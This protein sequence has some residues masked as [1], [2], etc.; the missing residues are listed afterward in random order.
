MKSVKRLIFVITI[1]IKPI[2]H[3][4][5]ASIAYGEKTLFSDLDLE[6]YPGNMYCIVGDSGQGKTSLL[7]SILGFIPLKKG[8]ICVQGVQLNKANILQTR[9]CSSWIPQELYLP[10]E[11]VKDMIAVPFKLQ[12]N[13]HLEFSDTRLKDYFDALGLD[14]DIL[15]R[16][17]TEI[18]GG[19]RQRLMI[20]VTAMLDKPLMI[21]DEPTSALDPHA[22]SLV[23]R[24][25]KDLNRKGVAVLAVS[26]DRIFAANC[27]KR[28]YL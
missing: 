21:I 23:I 1:M 7:K 6:L 10:E 2:L 8:S 26:H 5:R 22:I 15:N 13:R 19:Q 12:E 4:Q 24:F 14:H 16:R 28:I 18:S 25:L 17:V 20:A 11:W 27:D 3:I 9:R